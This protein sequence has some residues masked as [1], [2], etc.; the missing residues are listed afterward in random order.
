MTNMRRVTIAIP[1]ELDKQIMK[2]KQS[3]ADLA[4]A[5]Y[6]KVMRLV[7]DKGLTIISDKPEASDARPTA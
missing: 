5:S 1:D 6:S 7:L 4:R 2:L 3:D